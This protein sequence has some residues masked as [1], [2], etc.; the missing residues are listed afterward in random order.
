MNDEEEEEEASEAEY[1]FEWWVVELGRCKPD[2]GLFV[3]M[4]QSQTTRT[5]I[6][7]APY[8]VGIPIR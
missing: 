6:P 1:C 8:E 5:T 4:S 2:G 3:G 7:L